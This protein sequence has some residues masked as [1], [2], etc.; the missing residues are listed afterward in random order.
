[1][2]TQATKTLK[3]DFQ[4]YWHVGSGRSAGHHLDAVCLKDSHELPFVPGKQ[5]K[6][7]LRHAVRRAEDWGWY[8]EYADWFSVS[9]EHLLFGSESQT[10]D[11]HQLYAG[12][13]FIDDA[14]LSQAEY[15]FLADQ[16][17]ANLRSYLFDDLYSTAIDCQ[18]GTAKEH[19]LRG[20]EVALPM[21]LFADL[22][23]KVTAF[24]EQRREQQ[25]RLMDNGLAWQIL[26]Q[27]LPL[28]DAIGAQRSRGLGE[29]IVSYADVAA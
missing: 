21:C 9:I 4:N 25:Q 8:E 19:S 3:L 17:Q 1:M 26:A 5:L 23:L 29:V 27:A 13:L 18:T 20:I 16:S 22:H 2:T 10:E 11:R 28:I 15:D 12:M 14:H 7:L 6:G 24:D